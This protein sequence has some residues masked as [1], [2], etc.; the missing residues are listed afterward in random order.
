M[1]LVVWVY[2][3][4]GDTEAVGILPFLR[5]NLLNCTFELRSPKP[6]PGPRPGKVIYDGRTGRSLISEIRSDI[7]HFWDSSADIVILVDDVDDD[8]PDNREQALRNAALE[9]IRAKIQNQQGGRI[10]TITVCLAVPEVEIWLLADWSNTFGV[11]F[12]FCEWAAKRELVARG[13]DF[14]HPE[15]FGVRDERGRYANK[16]SDIIKEVILLKCEDKRTRL[17]MKYSKATDTPDLLRHADPAAISR[18]CK[19]FRRF[20]TVINPLCGAARGTRA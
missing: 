5:S 15:R 17:G 10:P 16:I 3:G 9:S 2:A 11:S 19:Y 4:G 18:K 14:D 8:D 13:V 12:S 1:A 20:W 6:K 7:Q